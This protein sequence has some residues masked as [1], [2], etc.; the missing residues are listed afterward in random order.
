MQIKIEDVLEAV[1]ERSGATY[2]IANLIK[3]KIE[4]WERDVSEVRKY[5]KILKEKGYVENYETSYKR[6]LS[7]RIIEKKDKQCK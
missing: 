1:Q 2:Y 7:W 6:Q 3:N 4:N 5:L